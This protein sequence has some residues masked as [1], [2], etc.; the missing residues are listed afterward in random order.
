[1]HH[2]HSGTQGRK[3]PY[4]RHREGPGPCG[5]VCRYRQLYKWPRLSEG[6]VS[7]MLSDLPSGEVEAATAA[8][9]VSVADCE[10]GGVNVPKLA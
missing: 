4:E 1:M 5:W 8:G 10:S 7:N 2:P 6:K 9:A 3:Y